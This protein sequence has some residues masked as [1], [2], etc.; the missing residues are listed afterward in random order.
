ME[1]EQKS[2]NLIVFKQ[3]SGQ[4]FLTFLPENS[5][6]TAVLPP[7]LPSDSERSTH[8]SDNYID[9]MVVKD[10]EVQ[11]ASDIVY[12]DLNNLQYIIAKQQQLLLSSLNTTS[13]SEGN[14]NC[15]TDDQKVAS[16]NGNTPDTFSNGNNDG[17]EVSAR[18]EIAEEEAEMNDQF[19]WKLK[20]R[21]DG[22]R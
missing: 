15:A 3:D 8:S 12:T 4:S 18:L 16:N 5:H 6:Q 21:S 11:S 22:S 13:K 1:G 9:P 2:N 17:K 20:I 7:S 10:G 14:D 19:E